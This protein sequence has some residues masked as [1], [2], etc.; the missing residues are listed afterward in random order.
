[1][2]AIPIAL[3][4]DYPWYSF[5]V[6]LENVTYTFTVAFNTR[7]N[8]W[9]LSIGDAVG[10]QIVAGFPLLIGRDLLA[11]YRTQAV[12]PGYL[13]AFDTSGQGLQPTAASFLTDHQLVY[14]ETGTL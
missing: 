1:M 14:F 9:Y 2:A 10:N 5:S 6:T 11:A 12:P 8:R 3:N 4:E 13:F 7:A